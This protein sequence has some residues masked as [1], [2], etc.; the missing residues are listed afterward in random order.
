MVPYIK[1]I[2]IRNI[3]NILKNIVIPIDDND[4]PLTPSS[5][6]HLFLTGKNGSGKTILLESIISYIIY[7]NNLAFDIVN[8]KNNFLMYYRI[9]KLDKTERNKKSYD[10]FMDILSNLR[11]KIIVRTLTSE[12]EFQYLI[13]NKKIFIAYYEASRKPQFIQPKSPELPDNGSLRNLRQ[14]KTEVFLSYLVHLKVQRSLQRDEGHSDIANS[15]DQ[16]FEK[17]DNLLK[18]IFDDEEAKMRFSP[19]NYGLDVILKDNKISPMMYLSDGYK[20]LMDIICD[21]IIKMRS[22]NGFTFAYETPGIVFIDE[23]ETHLHLQL[24]SNIMPILTELFPKI[25]FI[26]T[27]HSPLVLRSI[28]NAVVFDMEKRIPISD[29]ENYTYDSIAECYFDITQ[30]SSY[31]LDKIEKFRLLIQKKE[32][33][34]KTSNELKKLINEF[35][36]ISP[37]LNPALAAEISR[38]KVIYDL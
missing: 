32:E 13:K 8:V 3:H 34:G 12:L 5:P 4:H 21:M 27:T 16:W 29:M 1:K 19:S 18:K 11:S 36:Q 15:I 33:T 10:N 38:A 9:I 22:E 28:N 20:A 35:D 7:L 6:V 37:I 2:Q 17:F 31:I 25:Q 14:T 26:I 24:Q 30:Q 23:V